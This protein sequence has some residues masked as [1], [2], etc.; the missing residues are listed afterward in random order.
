M[1]RFFGVHELRLTLIL[2][3]AVF[4]I[5]HVSTRKQKKSKSGCSDIKQLVTVTVSL[6]AI[7][8]QL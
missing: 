7:L 8:S 4:K 6:N 1:T 2:T 5:I 3:P